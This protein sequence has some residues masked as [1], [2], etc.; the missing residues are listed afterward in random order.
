LGLL[1]A[2]T[3][4]LNKKYDD[5]DNLLKQIVV[6]PNEGASRGRQLYK[7]TKLM[8]AVQAMDKKRCKKA[9]G[10]ISDSR[11][12]PENLGVGK[13]YQENIDERLEDWMAYLCYKKSGNK[14]KAQQML[15][16]IT[17]YTKYVNEEGDINA[18]VNNLVTA[19]AMKANGEADK[20]YDFLNQWNEDV[21]DNP[22]AKWVLAT[23]NGNNAKPLENNANDINY[24]VLKELIKVK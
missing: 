12:W 10:Y 9:L 21:P 4:L 20:A 17:R 13:P 23:F 18:S 2:Q 19:W 16:K 15:D 5:A 1:Y 22:V 3:L 8:L 11:I 14:T 7:E 6:L 24:L